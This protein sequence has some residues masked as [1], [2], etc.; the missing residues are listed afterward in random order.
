MK[1]YL[2]LSV[3]L[4]CLVIFIACEKSSTEV[5]DKDVSYFIT[6]TNGCSTEITE[7]II[8][9]VGSEDIQEISTLYIGETTD[10]FEFVL[11]PPSDDNPISFGDYSLSYKQNNEEHY[12]GIT[13]PDTH[14]SV[15]I[16]DEGF[17][18]DDMSYFI[19]IKNMS[20]YHISNIEIAMDGA[21]ETYQIDELIINES[22]SEFE[23]HLVNSNAVSCNFG[24]YWG[25]Y[26]QNEIMKPI[27]LSPIGHNNILMV[28]F[29]DSL[30]FS[31]EE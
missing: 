30:G 24:C 11:P 3:I 10:N 1:K 2:V 31:I 16:E 27:L 25:S 19:T 9:M 6:V 14:I 23:F 18:V 13:L 12:F 28:I 22:S 26:F 21:L 5:D 29:D 17:T 15:L 7:S 20:S 8:S 4:F